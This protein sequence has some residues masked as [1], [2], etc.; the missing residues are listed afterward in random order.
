MAD[1]KKIEIFSLGR[2]WGLYPG[3]P[4]KTTLQHVVDVRAAIT[5]PV[6][7]HPGRPGTDPEVA[8][9]IKSQPGFDRWFKDL[10]EQVL[11]W[12][13]GLKR[14]DFTV[15]KIYLTCNGG[16]QRSVFVADLVAEQLAF[17]G[18]GRAKQ[19][20]I[21]VTHLSLR[22]VQEYQFKQAITVDQQ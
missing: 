20:E 8:G 13:D 14:S 12:S 2:R 17:W 7:E 10:M 3:P 4:D 18:D 1:Q 21:S 9:F 11:R 16:F 19:H 22:L 15:L 6:K 5:D